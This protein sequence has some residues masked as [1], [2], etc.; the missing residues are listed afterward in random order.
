MQTR[1]L[2]LRVPANLHEVWKR[3]ARGL[4]VSLN[5]YLI[6]CVQR[7]RG[8]SRAADDAVGVEQ[9]A[10]EVARL[11]GNV[12]EIGRSFEV[13]RRAITEKAY[14]DIDLERARES[15]LSILLDDNNVD[16]IKRIVSR[17]YLRRYIAGKNPLLERYLIPT[18]DRPQ[19]LL[20]DILFDLEAQRLVNV[21]AEGNIQW[22]ARLW[23]KKEDTTTKGY[24]RK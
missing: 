8:S 18:P 1:Q 3:E 9:L 21:S 24:Q 23:E 14:A 15:L 19:T 17:E 20:D 2:T 22:G 16:E 7:D 4:R 6:T 11:T 5:S 13:I 10:G 12:S